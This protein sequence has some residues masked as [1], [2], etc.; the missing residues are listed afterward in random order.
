[1]AKSEVKLTA[2]I[3]PQSA[4]AGLNAIGQ[5]ADN[6]ATK[7]HNAAG[8]VQSAFTGAT[9]TLIN[10][11]R[12]FQD[13]PYGMI[14]IA[15][16]IEPLTTSFMQMSKSMNEATGKANGMFGALKM[17]GASLMTPAGIVMSLASI[18]PS[19]WMMYDK[20]FGDVQKQASLTEQFMQKIKITDAIIPSN[21]GF[22]LT[23]TINLIDRYSKEISKFDTIVGKMKSAVNARGTSLVAGSGL[24]VEE[25][26]YYD[27]NKDDIETK[28]VQL[29]L[30]QKQ[31]TELKAQARLSLDLQEAGAVDLDYQKQMQKI[32]DDISKKKAI[33]N[34]GTEEQKKIASI[35]I[36]GLIAL[37]TAFEE[38]QNQRE[39]VA[40]VYTDEAKRVDKLTELADK[41]KQLSLAIAEQYQLEIDITKQNQ[42]LKDSK[43]K[44]WEFDKN[45][46]STQREMALLE[47]E[48]SIENG[49]TLEYRKSQI[50]TEYKIAEL[51]IEQAKLIKDHK[52]KEAEITAYYDTQVQLNLD[53]LELKWKLLAAEAKRAGE[54]Y[55]AE[56]EYNR[57]LNEDK[58]KADREEKKKEAEKKKARA[59]Q[60]RTAER[61]ASTMNSIAWSA[62]SLEDFFVQAGRSLLMYLSEALIKMAIMKAMD[63]FGGNGKDSPSTIFDIPDGGVLTSL[64]SLGSAVFASEGRIMTKPTLTVVGE[65]REPEGVFPLS[66]LNNFVPKLDARVNGKQSP[67]ISEKSLTKA[68]QKVAIVLKSDGRTVADNNK[69]SA[70]T[71][72]KYNT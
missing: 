55:D 41:Y 62:K 32:T 35:Q 1:M 48:I 44:Q 33:L 60:E 3:D 59:E 45:S 42:D 69:K 12:I 28:R 9:P 30:L 25:Q 18:L 23:Q 10:V 46:L 56:K 47:A 58:E 11:N 26:A 16:N 38:Y 39:L 37:R 61:I 70:I 4:L 20:F 43:K 7:A 14:G 68:F 19:A 51:R 24:T 21:L 53:L 66:K 31:V 40:R 57:V 71:Y 6:M 65:G 13:M 67:T 5:G 2:T 8:R 34:S 17:L 64:V 22:T 49:N 36:D 29:E 50:E 54:S 15:N 72:G 27:A 63:I 52:D